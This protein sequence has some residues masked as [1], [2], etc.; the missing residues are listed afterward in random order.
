MALRRQHKYFFIALF[1]FIL[2]CVCFKKLIYFYAKSDNTNL[3]STLEINNGSALFLNNCGTCHLSKGHPATK[4]KPSLFPKKKSWYK[5][6]LNYLVMKMSDE[7]HRGN[8]SKELT[9]EELQNIAIFIKE[10]RPIWKFSNG[11]T[12]F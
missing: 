1:L 5:L 2:F 4:S 12:V 9:N 8:F 10:K 11:E 3:S 6:P 7:T